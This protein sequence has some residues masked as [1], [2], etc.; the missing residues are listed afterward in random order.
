MV[1]VETVQAEPRVRISTVPT[2]AVSTQTRRPPWAILGVSSGAWVERAGVSPTWPPPARAGAPH[3]PRQVALYVVR[4]SHPDQLA[5]LPGLGERD[6][7]GQALPSLLR[8]AAALGLA[9]GAASVE[10]AV[11]VWAQGVPWR[12]RYDPVEFPGFDPLFH[13]L[14]PRYL[15]GRPGSLIVLPDA[16]GPSELVQ[17]SAGWR[18]VPTSETDRAAAWRANIE[19]LIPTFNENR[20]VGLFDA[21]FGVTAENVAHTMSPLLGQPVAVCAWSGAAT[22]LAAHG[23]RSASAAAATGLLG[24]SG[25][26][27]RPGGLLG[28]TLPL[29][30]GRRPTSPIPQRQP[31]EYEEMPAHLVHL[32]LLPDGVSAKVMAEPTL[33]RPLGRWPLTA[34][35]T[36]RL[37]V[38]RVADVAETFVFR[39]SDATTAVELRLAL[40]RALSPFIREGV[41]AS[42]DPDTDPRISARA[43]ADHGAPRLEATIEAVLRPWTVT[44]QVAVEISGLGPPVVRVG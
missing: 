3:D 27:V 41:L 2:D 23:W 26:G 17:P 7:N 33:L 39:T 30:P 40:L 14:F 44:L 38:A 8:D 19:P 32:R 11:A 21:P 43:P 37:V 20:Q 22:E 12:F 16:G 13:E 28:R 35:W 24:V 36:A 1:R 5:L 4:I 6:A 34:I 31:A 29:G 25:D 18:Q 10:V 42:G 9:G 15:E